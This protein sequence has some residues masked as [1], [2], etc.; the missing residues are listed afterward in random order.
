LFT[1]EKE[2]IDTATWDSLEDEFNKEL[3]EEVELT[4]GVA[5]CPQRQ[6]VW[7]EESRRDKHM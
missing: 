5:L 4:C 6:T 1:R 2:D 3:E 7:K